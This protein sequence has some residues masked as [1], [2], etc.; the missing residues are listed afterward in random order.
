VFATVTQVC[1][2]AAERA[3]VD[4]PW[5]LYENDPNWVPPLRQRV[6][7]VFNRAKHPFYDHGDAAFFLAYRDGRPVGR[8]AAI[9]N[10]L[11]AEPNGERVGY[12][13]FF[14]CTPDPQV[15]EVLFST[16]FAWLRGRG[17]N[18][19][20]GPIN[21]AMHEECGTLLGPFDAPP[22]IMMAHNLEYY[23]Q[24]IEGCGFR[25]AKD[26]YAYWARWDAPLNPRMS[27]LADYARTR[28]GV[29]IRPFAL[30]HRRRDT[31]ALQSV[32]N[33]VFDSHWG[34]VP[35]GHREFSEIV[36]SL[37][38]IGDPDLVRI[39]E[40]AGRPVGFLII[41]PDANQ[42]LHRINGRMLPFG[43]LR[44]WMHMRRIDAARVLAV[45]VHPAYRFDGTDL[46][47]VMDAY[48]VGFAK[49]YRSVEMSWIL[50]D[51]HRMRLALEHAGARITRT[52]RVY[53][54]SLCAV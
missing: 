19:V 40:H 5:H 37:L 49:G 4:L 20:R 30:K 50:E 15:A 44:V 21:F 17:L 48:D 12:F 54:S 28:S 2:R 13:G 35:I 18:V 47:L 38:W 3:F 31:A 42:A 10:A 22:R 7:R 16:A 24:L 45:A 53:E 41:M 26:L 6:H 34:L 52:Y 51:N 1:S 29:T 9:H 11:H 25:K 39:A 23:A 32:Y 8:I 14:E 43:W 46:L 36:D 33:A 27:R